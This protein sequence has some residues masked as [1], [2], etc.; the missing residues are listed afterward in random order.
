MKSK[1]A[2][3]HLYRYL[4][5]A[6]ISALS[7]GEST[8]AAYSLES[9]QAVGSRIVALLEQSNFKLLA[10]DVCSGVRLGYSPY[11]RN[12][13]QLSITRFRAEQ[14]AEFD[15][16]RNKYRWGQYD[17]TGAEIRLTP[18]EYHREFVYD[19]DYLNLGQ[20]AYLDAA[21][22]QNNPELV[23]LQKAYPGSDVVVYRYPG[24][25]ELGYKDAKELIL[26]LKRN[27]HQWCLTGI[28]HS[29]DTV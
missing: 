9:L 25:E 18:I 14:I 24:H 23:G 17:G 7:F 12:L 3:H 16:N 6:L 2:A 13:S 5:V 26:I 20:A 21:A 10:R 27:N 4:A 15:T 11:T 8:R 19:V 22:V 29:E 28:S 1:G